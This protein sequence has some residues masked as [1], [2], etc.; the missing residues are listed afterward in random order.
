MIHN[1]SAHM[2]QDYTLN[3]RKRNQKAS[4]KQMEGLK[5]SW[6]LYCK[7]LHYMDGC[8]SKPCFCCGPRC[9]YL[10]FG[11]RLWGIKN[12]LIKNTYN[13]IRAANSLFNQCHRYGRCSLTEGLRDGYCTHKDYCKKFKCYLHLAYCWFGSINVKRIKTHCFFLAITSVIF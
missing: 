12:T 1:I 8:N 10:S 7:E 9:T 6:T 13:V 3:W 5:K 2:F 4:K 11:D